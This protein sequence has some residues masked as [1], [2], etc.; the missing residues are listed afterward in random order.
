[1]Y[2]MFIEEAESQ[3]ATQKDKISKVCI[4]FHL[5]IRILHQTNK[6]CN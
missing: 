3:M 4:D 6:K 2:E 5:K 1:M